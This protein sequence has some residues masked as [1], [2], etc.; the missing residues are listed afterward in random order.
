MRIGTSAMI[1][2][3]KNNMAVPSNRLGDLYSQ[4]SSGKKLQEPSDD[5][6]A[7]AR[8][9]SGQ[10]A[11]NELTARKFVLQQGTEF[12]GATDTA[13][14]QISQSLSQIQDVALQANEPELTDDQR[15]ALAD[16]VR[17]TSS[18]LVTAG[19]SEVQGQYI[20]AGSQTGTTPFVAASGQNL[21]VM[22]DGNN[23]Q[24]SYMITSSEQAPVGFTGAQVFN[25]PDAQGNRPLSGVT[26]DTFSL[27]NNLANSIESGDTAQTTSLTDQL[28]Q[29]YSYVV[30][31]RGENGIVAQRYQSASTVADDTGVQVQTMLS[32]DQ[33]VD[34]ASAMTDLSQEETAYQAALSVTSKLL[35]TPNLFE[36]S[37][38]A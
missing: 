12:V 22:Y 23:Q 21:P 30:G 18:A 33:D 38:Q 15:S 1:D 36:T 11:L 6:L 25:F 3:L 9:V 5:P 34:Y 28:N 2:V 24:L 31:L 20:F 17:E 13:L 35:Q 16:Q 8:V 37:W 32:S 19:N 29:T 4:L 14:G 26:M 7:A 10:A 27:L